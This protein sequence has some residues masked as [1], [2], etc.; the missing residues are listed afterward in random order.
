AVQDLGMDVHLPERDLSH[1]VEAHDHHAGHPQ[2]DDV[3]AGDEDAS[4]VEVIKDLVACAGRG[5]RLAV[6]GRIMLAIGP[7]ESG[8]RPEGRAEP[9]V[10]DVGIPY[11]ITAFIEFTFE[12]FVAGRNTNERHY[13]SVL[14][15]LDLQGG[16]IRFR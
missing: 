11:E 14:H 10:E 4:G 8:V 12:T 1:V 3:A 16:D 2:R 5:I 6:E 7:A 13:P 9:G 15:W